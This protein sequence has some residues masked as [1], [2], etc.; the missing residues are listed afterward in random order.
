MPSDSPDY[1]PACIYCHEASRHGP[2]AGGCIECRCRNV[3]SADRL[4][5]EIF[6]KSDAE[7]DD[8]G[9]SR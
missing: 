6:G 5:W 7:G 8:I 4:L 2:E 9:N 3:G 1:D